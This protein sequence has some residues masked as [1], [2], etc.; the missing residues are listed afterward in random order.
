MKKVEVLGKVF[1]CHASH[2]EKSWSGER[3]FVSMTTSKSE[4]SKW[5]RIGCVRHLSR[6]PENVL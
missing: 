3:G 6:G 4:G 5:E 1:A 2:L